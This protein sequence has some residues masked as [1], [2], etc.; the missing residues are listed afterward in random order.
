MINQYLKS[1]YSFIISSL[2]LLLI[3][4]DSAGLLSQSPENTQ[5]PPLASPTV[6]LERIDI[7]A[8]PITTS[9]VS[10]L[11][12]AVGHKQPFEVMG[13]Y[14]DGSSRPLTD[15]EVSHWRTSDPD[16]GRFDEPG[17]L[18]ATQEGVTT[19]TV[20]K[21]GV[22]SNAVTVN[23]SD[24]VITSI[25]V[26]PS[27]VNIVKG[28]TEPLTATAIFSDMTSSDVSDL[29]TWI[30]VDTETATVTPT[31]SLTAV[32]VGSTTL[33][34]SMDG[35]TS[36]TVTVNVSAPVMTSIQ[37]TPSRVDMAIG[38]TQQ[39]TATAIFNNGT[40]SDVSSSVTWVSDNP[41]IASVTPTGSLTADNVGS[42]T[43][44]ASMDGV[45]SNAVTVN[46]SAPVMTSIQ[47]T[48]SRVDMA[49]G[50]T[51]Q[52]TA[53]AI[54][55]DRTSSDVSSSVTWVSDNPG[56]ASV[57]QTGLLSADGVGSTTLT[58]SMDG[59]TSNTVDVNVSDATISSIQVTPSRVDMA[60]G[61]GLTQQ[62][63]AIATF[64]NGTS[65]DV[66]SSVTWVS[67]N[68]AIASVTP[69][70]LLSAD[71]VGI[72]TLTASMNGVT[73]NTGHPIH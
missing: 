28:L 6:A 57:T 58:A 7:V 42:T 59:V 26:T 69:T 56:I 30:L 64:D 67:D 63:T 33:T 61:L 3:G 21:D 54:F 34:A 47:V 20:T 25:Q 11:T 10:N 35:V 24:A 19:I 52:L 49:R 53:I 38:Q 44:T 36:N 62:L 2:L 23:V 72:T 37:V 16:V 9:G 4:C 15:L 48:P 50:L 31:G 46:V 45:T 12:L 65:F 13:H 39:L 71:N 32:E 43:L 73:S 22:T 5:S 41:V 40:S 14:V 60:R 1:L 18:T 55:S 27:P 29:V 51:Q 17:V 8:S 66:S 70:G 68:P